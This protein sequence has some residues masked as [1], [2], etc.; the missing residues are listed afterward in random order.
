MSGHGADGPGRQGLPRLV[1]TVLL[2]ALAWS[3]ALVLTS[4][5]GRP[6]ETAAATIAGRTISSAELDEKARGPLFQIRMQEYEARLRVL[7]V[8]I[9]DEV[10]KREAE[11]R[12]MSAEEL[13]RA[14]VLQKA[15]AAT[16]EEIQSTYEGVKGR[17]A[18]KPEGEVKAQIEQEL[19]QQRLAER[20]Q[21]FLK[22]LKAKAGV[23]VWLE[24]PRLAVDPGDGV[25]RG[26][27]D[28]PVTIVE[29][30]DFQCPYC[31]RAAPTMKKIREVYGDRVRL[32]YRDMPLPIHP[33][34]PKAAE[35]A[36]CAGDQ[37]KFWEMHDRLFDA[38]GQ[39]EIADLKNYAGELG[40][41][42]AGFDTCLESGKNEPRWKAGKA[43]AEGYGISATPAFFLNGRFVSGARP[44]EVFAEIIDD[45]LARAARTKPAT[46][47]K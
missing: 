8:L 32:A 35:A 16:P 12:H 37:G 30:S 4:A 2:T 10:L 25:A 44:F 34:A 14:E 24:P 42:R 33:L 27:K 36:A 23:Q 31:V 45:E 3:A 26:P 22:E 29:F 38:K 7:N 11:A 6:T 28:A 39:L 43:A 15:A 20:R 46:E 9:A 47:S 21:V 5:E 17:F 1:R 40:L 41:D 13:L 18:N 19:K